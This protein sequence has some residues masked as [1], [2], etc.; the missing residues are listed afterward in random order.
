[1]KTEIGINSI[2]LLICAAAC[3][4]CLSCPLAGELVAAHY[5][6]DARWY[7]ARIIHL[8]TDPKL[9]DRPPP[10]THA[11]VEYIDFGNFEWVSLS[12]YASH[13]Y[14][15]ST[16]HPLNHVGDNKVILPCC[17]LELS[18]FLVLCA[19]LLFSELYSSQT[20]CLKN[21]V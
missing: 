2:L 13:W 1:M 3:D 12:R 4:Q 8:A 20:P 6:L 7:R 18:V 10:N 5:D 15:S 21:L 17:A 19:V 14:T 11:R 16:M 9:P